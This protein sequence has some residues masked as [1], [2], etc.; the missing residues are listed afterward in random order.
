MPSKTSVDRSRARKSSPRVAGNRAAA[1]RAPR[2][3]RD[4]EGAE[5]ERRERV[6]DVLNQL[7]ADCLDLGMQLKQAHWNVK[8]PHFSALHA[9]F[10]ESWETVTA[11]TDELAE[12]IVALGGVAKG[13]LQSV[14]QGSRLKPYPAD[15]HSG[16]CHAATLSVALIGYGRSIRL[17]INVCE[18]AREPGS[19]DVCTGI[20]RKTDEI[21]WKIGAHL[22]GM[23]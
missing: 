3:A 12:R 19:A 9:L 14:A 16:I 10:D 13:T 7:L 22:Q 21:T 11:F 1:S 4:G 23:A 5:A 8:G 6:V 20:S 15:M 18:E 2:G 17:A